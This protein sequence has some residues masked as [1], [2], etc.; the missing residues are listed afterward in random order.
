MVAVWPPRSVVMSRAAMSLPTGA[1]GLPGMAFCD[2]A[3]DARNK[4]RRNDVAA[5]DRIMVVRFPAARKKILSQ[6]KARDV[7]RPGTAAAPLIA[8]GRTALPP[9]SV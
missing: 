7:V 1:S 8:P 6:P 2:V 9:P 4:Q 5:G 3:V